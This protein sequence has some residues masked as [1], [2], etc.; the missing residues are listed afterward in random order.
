MLYNYQE[1]FVCMLSFPVVLNIL[2]PLAMLVIWLLKQLVAGKMKNSK[3]DVAGG[4]SPIR[5]AN[6]SLLGN[7]LRKAWV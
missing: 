4:K 7:K 2:L 6:R 3:N 1:I 5:M